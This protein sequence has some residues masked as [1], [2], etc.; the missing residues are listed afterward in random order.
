MSSTAREVFESFKLRIAD[1]WT[2]IVEGASQ[3][4]NGKFTVRFG[5]TYKTM[6]VEEAIPGKQVV[7]KCIDAL[8]DISEQKNKREWIGTKI[9][10][11]IQS[12]SNRTKITLTHIGLTT[13]FECYDVCEKGWTFFFTESLY[14]I[15]TTN[16][17]LPYKHV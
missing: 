11:D 12:E 13:D 16:Q 3:K 5:N 14:K 10:W 15:L 7:W 8:I 9:V 4:T 2:L 1:W 17:G 6:L